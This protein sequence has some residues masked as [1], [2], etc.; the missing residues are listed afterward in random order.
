MAEN[1]IT[2]IKLIYDLLHTTKSSAHVKDICTGKYVDSNE[3]NVKKFGFAKAEEIIGATIWDLHDFM[4]P[5]WGNNLV[6]DIEILEQK[7]IST[8]KPMSDKRAFLA[9]SGKIWVHDMTKIP[10]LNSKGNVC[11]IFTLSENITHKY[12]LMDLWKVYL[13]LY[14][15]K[16]IAIANYLEHINIAK[17][18]NELIT[19]GELMVLI[20]KVKIPHSKGIAKILDISPR[21]VDCH[22]AK[23]KDKAKIDINEITSIIRILEY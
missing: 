18:F 8:Q 22:I 2:S 5:Y 4:K 6:N 10:I 17:L 9:K 16:K 12:E 20:S 14:S 21:T 19:E 3:I 15:A 11:S 13:S 7:V 23:L 1:D